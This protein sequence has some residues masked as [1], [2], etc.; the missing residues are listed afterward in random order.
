MHCL[1]RSLNL[2]QQFIYLKYL[3][4]VLHFV[5][6]KASG[7]SWKKVKFCG[8]FRN[9]FVQKKADFMGNLWK[10]LGQILLKKQLVE[11]G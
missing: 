10:F 9:N 7:K 1:I 5:I 11:N 6:N 3:E 8:N 4:T 2:I